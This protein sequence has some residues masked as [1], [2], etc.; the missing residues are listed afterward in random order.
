MIIA[1]VLTAV[2]FILRIPAVK[3]SV[4]DMSLSK[5]IS[6][7]AVMVPKGLAAVVLASI[8]IQQGVIGGE[9]I[10]NITYG[11]VLFSI[12]ITSFLVILLEKTKLPSL[13]VWAMAPK[14]P[15]M[16]H[17]MESRPIDI[18]G[19]TGDIIPTGGKLFGVAEDNEKKKLHEDDRKS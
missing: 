17:K 12:V 6:V 2:A 13:Y 10:K 18:A 1:L 8:P 5:D 7:M 15:G 16:R 11:V 19:K 9:M 3:L 14:L 4:K